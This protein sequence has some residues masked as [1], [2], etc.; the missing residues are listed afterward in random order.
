MIYG[1]EA[2]LANVLT[3]ADVLVA[4]EVVLANATRSPWPFA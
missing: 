2:Q 4:N 3:T 1:D